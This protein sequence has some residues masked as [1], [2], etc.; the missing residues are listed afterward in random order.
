MI[1][2]EGLLIYERLLWLRVVSFSLSLA[3]MGK[4]I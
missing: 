4:M 2:G 3:D 1:G